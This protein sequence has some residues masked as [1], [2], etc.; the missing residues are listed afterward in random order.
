LTVDSRLEIDCDATTDSLANTTAH[1]YTCRSTTQDSGTGLSTGAK[2]GIGVG[3][4]VGGL[5]ILG[6][7]ARCVARWKKQTAKLMSASKS[8]IQLNKVPL[9]YGEV[10]GQGHPPKYAETREAN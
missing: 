8:H 7:A 9:I 4:G 3:A 10:S 1:P 6:A 2:A 5:L